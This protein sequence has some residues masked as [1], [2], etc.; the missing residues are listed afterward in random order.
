MKT[1]E[2]TKENLNSPLTTGDSIMKRYDWKMESSQLSNWPK[3]TKFIL[4]DEV[5]EI[6]QQIIKSLRSDLREFSI[7]YVF[8]EKASQNGERIVLGQVKCE[9]ALQKILHGLDAIVIIGFNTWHELKPDNKFALVTH[10]LEHLAADEKSGRL[11]TI[12]HTVEEFP[13]VIEIFGPQQT[14]HVLFI[15]AFETFKQHNK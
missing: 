10:E 15:H 6:G 11:K 2:T 7:G 5:K 12:P 9:N 14:N 4:S 1:N 13:K 3:D 8:K